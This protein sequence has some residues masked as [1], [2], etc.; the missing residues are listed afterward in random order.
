MIYFF[1]RN[2]GRK[3]PQALK[4]HGHDVVVHDDYFG[5]ATIDEHWLAEV[6]R[7]GWTVLTKDDRIRFNDV[8]FAVLLRYKV[9]CFTMMRRND[10]WE[11]L[12]DSLL[13]AWPRIE[14]ISASETRPFMYAIYQDGS[15]QKRDLS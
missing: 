15:I 6:G 12:R 9:G 3:V 7:R 13:L 14:E 11:Q 4:E 2:F 5:Q 8:E 1:D 10:P